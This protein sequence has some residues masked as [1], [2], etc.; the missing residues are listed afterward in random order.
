MKSPFLEIKNHI[1]GSSNFD[2]SRPIRILCGRF[3]NM[4]MRLPPISL[5]N[6]KTV[7]DEARW[8]A[9]KLNEYAASLEALDST[10]LDQEQN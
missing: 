4:A 6:T 7:A 10:Q 1:S 5:A 3:E 9:K 8:L 2:H